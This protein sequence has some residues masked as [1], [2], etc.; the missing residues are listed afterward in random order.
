SEARYTRL[1]SQ[2]AARSGR[3]AF[4]GAK[5]AMWPLVGPITSGFG[6][7]WGGFHNGIAIAAAMYPP[8]RAA[9]SGQVV[10]GV[11]PYVSYGAPAVV[12]IISH[13]YNFSTLYG[14]LDDSRWPPVRVGQFVAA[15]TVIGYVGMNGWATRP[16]C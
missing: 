13:G 10:T 5:V 7:R 3:G 8:I 1:A 16:H 9:S 11:R 4:N 6:P 2:L 15:G 12:V 14:H